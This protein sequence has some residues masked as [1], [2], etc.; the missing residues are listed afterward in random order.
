MSVQ[1]GQTRPFESGKPIE[2]ADKQT[3]D[4]VDLAIPRGGAISGRILDEFGESSPDT[5]VASC[6]L[7]GRTANGGSRQYR[8]TGLAHRR[9]G[10]L[11]RLRTSPRRV[12]RQ[13]DARQA[14]QMLGTMP[15][16][17][18]GINFGL[19]QASRLVPTRNRR[20]APA[21]RRPTFQV[22][23]TRRKRRRSPSPRVRKSSNVDFQLAA[24]RLAKVSGF[25]MN[26]E[27]R[28][29]GGTNVTLASHDV[30]TRVLGDQNSA[31]TAQDGSFAFSNVAPGDYVLRAEAMQ[32]MTTHGDNNM[33]VFRATRIG[34]E[35]GEVEVGIDSGGGLR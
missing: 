19:G 4:N 3:L 28:P 17:I 10:S 31:R 24:V 20:R 34:G 2:L 5:G 21:T 22:R 6:A 15:D 35:G 1:Y 13:R 30:R 23:R 32:I 16:P 29:A 33:M 11:P 8:W 18:Q 9:F 25:V 14:V 27:G 7:A 12:L 26:S